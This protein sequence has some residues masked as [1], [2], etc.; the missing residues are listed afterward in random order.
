M[1]D[2]VKAV[3]TAI[4]AVVVIRLAIEVLFASAGI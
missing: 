4:I 3:I 2:F 1:I